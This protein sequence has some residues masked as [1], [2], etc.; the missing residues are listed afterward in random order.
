MKCI[1]CQTDNTLKD[2]TDNH[3]RCK[4]CQHPFVFEPTSMGA[5]K[6]TDMMF[7]KAIADL[8]ANDTLFFT[9]KQLFYLFNKHLQGRGM[10]QP[11]GLLILSGFATVFALVTIVLPG[12]EKGYWGFLLIPIVINGLCLWELWHRSQSQRVSSQERGYASRCLQVHGWAILVFGMIFGLNLNL[13]PF[14]AGSVV[15]GLAAVY[16]GRRGWINRAAI[17][18]VALLEWAK[19][20]EWLTSWQTV[21]PIT[22][23]LEPPKETQ[24]ALNVNPDVTAYSFDRLVVTDSAAIAQ[25]LIANNFHF[26]NNCAILSVTGYP[27]GIFLTAM[28]MLRRNPELKV[29]AF[30]DCSGKGMGLAHHL[31]TSPQWFQNSPVEIVDVGLLP[32]QILSIPSVFV[33][34]ST[35]FAG[36]SKRLTDLER[37]QFTADELAWLD[38]GNAVLLESFTPQR[39]IQ[40]LNRGIAASREFLEKDSS[41]G[42]SDGSDSIFIGDGGSPHYSVESFG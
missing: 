15:V 41:S 7:A 37:R 4:Q 31:R 38:E 23:I 20:Q 27:Q 6:V 1:Q 40:A 35:E 9:P 28:E 34:Q 16:W 13:F 10:L 25:L 39:L 11:I 17:S 3:G 19:F 5:T 33:Q 30:H 22:K 12:L 21:N 8:S 18:S 29:Y 32:R 14:F 2:R 26:E 24:V 36:A 42:G